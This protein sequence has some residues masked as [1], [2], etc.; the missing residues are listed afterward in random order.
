[1]KINQPV[2]SFTPV[3]LTIETEDELAFMIRLF[4]ATKGS[5]DEPF[6]LG[7]EDNLEVFTDLLRLLDNGKINNYP[8][9]TINL[10]KEQS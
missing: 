8:E 1:M 7:S 6:N 3:T 4:G 2:K 5:T 10:Q 9:F